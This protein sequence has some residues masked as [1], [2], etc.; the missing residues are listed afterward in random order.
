MRKRT[1]KLD[2]QTKITIL[3]YERDHALMNILDLYRYMQ[4]SK[5][6]YESE[7]QGYISTTDV[8]DRLGS[9]VAYLQKPTQ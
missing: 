1:T 6:T 5:F 9:V 7:L 3:E 4:S 2:L 8:F